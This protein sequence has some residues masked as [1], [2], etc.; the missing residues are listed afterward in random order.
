MNFF[1]DMILILLLLKMPDSEKI[2]CKKE[3]QSS[4]EISKIA[5]N[6]ANVYLGL[7][8]RKTGYFSMDPFR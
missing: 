7:F 3:I 6:F 1:L 2:R 8:C 5:F 4:K